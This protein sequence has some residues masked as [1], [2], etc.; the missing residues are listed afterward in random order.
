MA[1]YDLKLLDCTLRDG[2]YVNDWKWGFS[3]AKAIIR[4]LTRANVDF[5]EVGFLRN[6]NEYDPDITVCSHIEE[7]NLLL[8]D[9]HGNTVYSAMAMRS[10]YDVSKLTP[11][12]GTGIE[13]IRIT[14]HDYDII[15]GMDFACEVKAKGYKL[16]I[17]PINI[18][19]YS[20]EQI[21]RILQQVN[22]IQPYQFSIVDT[23][24]SMK[25]RE[26]G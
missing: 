8:P 5:V 16:S 3:C 23:F 22:E 9:E 2:G 13:L 10:N 14:A 12:N 24:G 21:L 1:L 6:V 19:G 15:E 4:A 25:R 20:D 18:M 17:N 7:L 11:Y 26:S